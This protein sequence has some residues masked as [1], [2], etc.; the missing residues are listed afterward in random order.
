MGLSQAPKLQA[1]TPNPQR[2][3]RLAGLTQVQG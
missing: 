3:A 2:L 1:P